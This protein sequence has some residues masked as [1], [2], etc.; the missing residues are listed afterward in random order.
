MGLRSNL[1]DELGSRVLLSEM[2]TTKFNASVFVMSAMF[3]VVFYDIRS[4]PHMRPASNLVRRRTN[5]VG[6][7]GV[8]TRNVG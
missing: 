6:G 2:E 4:K 5:S 3:A 8:S 1:F 7:G